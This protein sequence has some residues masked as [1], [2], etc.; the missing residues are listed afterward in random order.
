MRLFRL[1]GFTSTTPRTATSLGLGGA[2]ASLGLDVVLVDMSPRPRR[3][4]HRGLAGGC[5]LGSILEALASPD[6]DLEGMLVPQRVRGLRLLAANP[7]PRGLDTSPLASANL[8]ASILMRLQMKH[9][10]VIVDSPPAVEGLEAARWL[11]ARKHEREFD[12]FRDAIDPLAAVGVTPAGDGAADL[13]MVLVVG[14]PEGGD[15]AEI[16]PQPDGLSSPTPLRADRSERELV[17]RTY[18][19]SRTTIGSLQITAA[20]LRKHLGRH[21]KQSNIVALALRTSPVLQHV[22]SGRRGR[23]RPR[24]PHHPAC[25]SAPGGSRRRKLQVPFVE[26]SAPIRSC[27]KAPVRSIAGVRF[28]PCVGSRRAS[29]ASSHTKALCPSGLSVSVA[30]RLRDLPWCLMSSCSALPRRAGVAWEA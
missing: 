19:L 17:P 12:I 30:C 27:A 18:H 9:D 25:G 5:D 22:E 1:A 28:D 13:L 14:E 6:M 10:I 20:A 8:M 11:V 29:P 15:G 26:A 2:L 21:V 4:R 3:A 24:L 23:C 7:G 16:V